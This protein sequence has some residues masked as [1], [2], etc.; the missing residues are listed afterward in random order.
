MKATPE[1]SPSCRAHSSFCEDEERIRFISPENVSAKLLSNNS[2]LLEWRHGSTGWRAPT[3]L[4]RI[5]D[6]QGDKV[7]EREAFLEDH[8]ALIEDLNKLETYSLVFCP[9]GAEV[10]SELGSVRF[11]LSIHNL[12]G[13]DTWGA[14]VSDVGLQA[15][16]DWR[17]SIQVEW[18]SG[19][20]VGAASGPEGEQ[21]YNYRMPDNYKL[22]LRIGEGTIR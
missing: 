5:L 14:F 4:I 13:P 8:D 16:V 21:D 20:A 9:S 18:R 7:F 22:T 10:P 2:I 17:G 1:I 12:E 19:R 3:R 15:S 6:R 11:Q